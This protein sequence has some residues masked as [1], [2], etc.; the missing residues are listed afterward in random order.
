MGKCLHSHERRLEGASLHLL[1]LGLSTV[2]AAGLAGAPQA[3]ADDYGA[4]I[5]TN[6]AA[7]QL[8]SAP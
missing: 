3:L 8:V 5:W 4:T 1:L 7:Q 2:A 6:D